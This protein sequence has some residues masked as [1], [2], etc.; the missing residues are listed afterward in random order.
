MVFLVFVDSFL[1]AEMET[2]GGKSYFLFL[3]RHF[4]NLQRQNAIGDRELFKVLKVSVF[5]VC[6][7]LEGGVY[8]WTCILVL[9]RSSLF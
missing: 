4:V 3:G 8:M 2:I 6:D 1:Q 9:Q 7:W 5:A